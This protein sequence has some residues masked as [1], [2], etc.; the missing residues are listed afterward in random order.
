[1]ITSSDV[2]EKYD[3]INN[4]GTF[5]IPDIIFI[6]IIFLSIILA[7]LLIVSRRKRHK[8]SPEDNLLTADSVDEMPIYDFLD[9][10]DEQYAMA[11]DV[12]CYILYNVDKEKYYVGKA[13]LCAD[14]VN[15]Q[16]IGKG[17]PDIFY[18]KKNGD[19]F[20]VQFY[21]V[22]EGSAYSTADE[23]YDDILTVYGENSEIIG[24]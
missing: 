13:P 20:T 23:L 10:T 9:I 18:E 1:M 24:I 8:H 5:I 3:N 11:N 7:I 14:A 17:S 19:E 16:L 22:C 21:F 2:W 15:R 12:G 6:L 4:S